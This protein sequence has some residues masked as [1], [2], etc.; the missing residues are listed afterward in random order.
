MLLAVIL[1]VTVAIRAPFL[2]NAVLGG[3]A[4]YHAHAAITVL[5]GGLLY[6]DVPYTYPPLYAYTEALSIAVFG[7]TTVGWKMVAQVYDLGSMVLIFLIGSRVSGRNKGLVAAVLYALSPLPLIATSSFACFDSTAAFWMLASLLLLLDRKEFPSAVALGVGA[8]YKYFPILLLPPLLLHVSGN[9]RRILYAT[10]TIAT[11]VLIQVPFMLTD[12]AAWFGNVILYHA[13]RP[14]FGASIYNLLRFNPTLGDVP[15]SSLTLLFPVALLLTFLLVTLDR[16][17]SQLGLLKKLCLVMLVAVFF[18]K[19]VLFYAL[20][21][22][23]LLCI[24]FVGIERK[25]TLLVLLAPFFTMQAA[26]LLAWYFSDVSAIGNA[27]AIAY[28]YLVSSALLLAWLL[29]DRLLSVG[30][31]FRDTSQ[32]WL[33]RNV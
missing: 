12:F 25:R 24:V 32:A 1:V 27:L 10:V 26:L 2:Q 15:Q 5:N 14:A 7:D 29:R 21:F 20:W 23:P 6:R 8:A 28:L 4:A 13:S 11:V 19:V 17:K 9:R 31:R 22:I 30:E 18:N 16:D 3:D 33:R